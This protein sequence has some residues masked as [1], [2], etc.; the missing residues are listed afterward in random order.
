MSESILIILIGSALI[1]TILFGDT[2]D[3]KSDEIKEMEDKS[4][5]DINRCAHCGEPFYANEDHDCDND[6]G[7]PGYAERREIIDRR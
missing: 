3:W 7:T 1:C 6:E 2:D 5:E 4:E